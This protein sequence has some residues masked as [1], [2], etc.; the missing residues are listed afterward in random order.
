MP[1]IGPPG[2]AKESFDL[3]IIAIFKNNWS[4][5]HV[6]FDL[7]AEKSFFP[8]R[9]LYRKLWRENKIV[10]RQRN[11]L[12]CEKDWVPGQKGDGGYCLSLVDSFLLRLESHFTS[13]YVHLTYNWPLVDLKWTVIDLYMNGFSVNSH[14]TVTF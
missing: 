6:E 11:G 14:S 5:F 8:K 9:I 2:N 4:N 3:R 1:G 13:W 7:F 10:I 12:K